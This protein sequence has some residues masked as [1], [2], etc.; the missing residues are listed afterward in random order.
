MALKEKRMPNFT[1]GAFEDSGRSRIRATGR[2]TCFK[3]PR[4]SRPTSLRSFRRSS[5]DRKADRVAKLQRSLLMVPL[6]GFLPAS[7]ERVRN[8]VKRIQN[9]L[10]VDG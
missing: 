8:T 1:T 7:D 10:M 3:H 6:V 9:E 5:S 2:K 4:R